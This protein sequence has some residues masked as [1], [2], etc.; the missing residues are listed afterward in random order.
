M[1][2]KL[3]VGSCVVYA[4]TV[5]GT[6]RKGEP[7]YFCGKWFLYLNVFKCYRYKC[8]FPGSVKHLGPIAQSKFNAGLNYHRVK[9]HGNTKMDCTKQV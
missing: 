4:A 3:I 2:Q 1:E 6:Q 5:R 9:Y 8:A 7:A